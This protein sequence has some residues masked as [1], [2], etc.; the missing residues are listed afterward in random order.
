MSAERQLK[1]TNFVGTLGAFGR[2]YGEEAREELVAQLEGPLGEALR[3]GGLVASGWYGASWYAALLQ[4]IV[5]QVGGGDSTARTLAREAV[6]SDLRTLFKVVRLV[7]SPEMALKHSLRI[8]SRYV[9]GGAIEMVESKD[10]LTH[11]RFTE[12]HG[13]SGL[14]WWDFIGGIEAVLESMGA[15]QTWAR[16]VAGGQD[17]DDHLEVVLRWQT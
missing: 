9:D 15:R 13:Y 7:L 16:V 10:G 2:E 8:S 5:D 12:Y 3:H 6:K 14:M 4:A 11:F 17:G 1:G